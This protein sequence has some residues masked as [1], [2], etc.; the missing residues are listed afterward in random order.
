MSCLNYQR[1]LITFWICFQT[2]LQASKCLVTNWSFIFP[3]GTHASSNFIRRCCCWYRYDTTIRQFTNM[4]VIVPKCKC[5]KGTPVRKGDEDNH[6]LEVSLA[7]APVTFPVVPAKIWYRTPTLISSRKTLVLVH[8]I[9]GSDP[10]T[11]PNQWDRLKW[12]LFDG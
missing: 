9:Q 4:H 11:Q 7:A 6:V 1:K 2:H 8:K 3:S 10:G 12:Y 5:L